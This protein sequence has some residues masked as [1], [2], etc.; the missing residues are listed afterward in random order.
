MTLTEFLEPFLTDSRKDKFKEVLD[1][2]TR[3]ATVVL[4]DIYQSQ[5]ASAVIRTCDCFGVQDVHIIENQNEYN[6][7]PDVALGASNWVDM[8][9]YNEGKDNTARC[10]K[11]LRKEG[12]RIV[13]TSPH[14]SQVSLPEFD[15]HKGKFALVFGTELTGVSDYV[16][17]NADEFMVIPMFGF[18]ESFNISVAAALCL[19]SIMTRLHCSE[20]AW[21]LS[22]DDYDEI[23]LA[24]L[25]QSIKHIDKVES[26]YYKEF[27]PSQKAR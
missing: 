9:Q 2:R 20:R 18:T 26:R 4:E 17:E 23:Y 21:K 24:W 25:R 11:K 10:F 7:N 16:M 5:N 14:S 8:H 15:I 6:L 22:Q 27:A 3:Y 19:Q 1:F 12:Y 13:A